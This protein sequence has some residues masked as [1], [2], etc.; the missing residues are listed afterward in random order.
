MN[1]I[2]GRKLNNIRFDDDDYVSKQM[3]YYIFDHDYSNDD[4]PQMSHSKNSMLKFNTEHKI[5]K[6]NKKQRN[7]NV[8]RRRR[9]QRNS[10]QKNSAKNCVNGKVKRTMPKHICDE[11]LKL[12]ENSGE[13][14]TCPICYQDIKDQLQLTTCGHKYCKSCFECI[15]SCGICNKSLTDP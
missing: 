9:N 8:N 1:A 5:V 3:M 10:N 6:K 4:E 2:T 13:T 11:I 14:I 12:A 7:R 15:D